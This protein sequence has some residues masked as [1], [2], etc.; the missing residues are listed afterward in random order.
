MGGGYPQLVW[1]A[2]GERERNL[3]RCSFS[4]SLSENNDAFLRRM[5]LQRGRGEIIR[6]PA[7][8]G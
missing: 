4:P 5:V 1:E 6:D 2:R 8:M 7:E 3:E